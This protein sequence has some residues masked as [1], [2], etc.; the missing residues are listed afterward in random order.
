MS[1]EDEAIELTD[2]DMAVIDDVNESYETEETSQEVE[3]DI[4]EPDVTSE[5]EYSDVE[6]SV[7]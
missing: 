2:E 7:T 5:D 1:E 3:S 6:E 4:V